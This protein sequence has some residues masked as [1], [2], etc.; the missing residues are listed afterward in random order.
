MERDYRRQTQDLKDRM[1]ATQ[2]QEMLI[3]GSSPTHLLTESLAFVLIEPKD[4][5]DWDKDIQQ[6]GYRTETAIT[7]WNPLPGPWKIRNLDVSGNCPATAREVIR[8]MLANGI[9]IDAT[10]AEI[11]TTEGEI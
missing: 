4:N 2:T 7:S 3:P 9:Y 8:D 11:T 1:M 6:H 10:D 5:G